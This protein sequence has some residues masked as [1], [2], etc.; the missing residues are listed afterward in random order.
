M[1]RRLTAAAAVAA[2]ALAMPA[3]AGAAATPTVSVSPSSVHPGTSV[4]VDGYGFPDLVDVVV[5][6]CGDGGLQ[7]SAD[8]ALSSSQETSTTSDG[9]FELDMVADQPPVPCPCVVLVTSEHLDSTPST[10]IDLIGAPSAPL[11]QA[12]APQ[13]TRPLRVVSVGLSGWGPWTSWFG[14]EPKRT[15]ELTV[16]NPNN[17]TYTDPPLVLRVGRAGTAG[18]VV[19]TQSIGD[20]GPGQTRILTV[21]VSMPPLSVGTMEVQGSLGYVGYRTSLQVG[22]FTFPWGL[23]ATLLALVQLTLLG[24]RNRARRHL[25]RA[26]A[27]LHEPPAPVS[28]PPLVTQAAP[29]GDALVHRLEP[30]DGDW[31]GRELCDPPIGSA[32]SLRRLSDHLQQARQQSDRHGG[33][34]VLG[35]V[36]ITAPGGGAPDPAD[37]SAVVAHM[38]SRLRA[39]DEV[40][41]LGPTMVAVVGRG[42]D[43][44]VPQAGR[45][46]APGVASRMVRMAE[47]ALR[48]AQVG[49]QGRAVAVSVEA[50]AHI[51]PGTI[52]RQAFGGLARAG[53]ANGG[54]HGG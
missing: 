49:G 26:H 45:G 19:S 12:A 35:M 25:A 10:S 1:I 8:C 32:P 44:D 16:E 9:R 47:D 29:L 2:A 40:V 39:E 13:V 33:S 34:V 42:G 14:G 6:V 21:P 43:P 36:E 30:L 28:V 18:S 46:P 54:G 27:A 48:T 15:L 53:M 3:A 22:T 5:Q 11:Q 7:A 38:R 41:P 37:V 51:D 52:T 31:L 4:A 17:T 23:L 50:G 24:L 20:F